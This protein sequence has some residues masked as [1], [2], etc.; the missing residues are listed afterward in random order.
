MVSLLN[1]TYSLEFTLYKASTPNRLFHFRSGRPATKCDT[2]HHS[3]MS[4]AGRPDYDQMDEL[5]A[6]D[7]EEDSDLPPRDETDGRGEGA[8][9]WWEEKVRDALEDWGWEAARGAII[10]SEE[11]DVVAS[12]LDDGRRIIVQCKDWASSTVTPATVWRLIG[13]C[14]TTGCRPVLAITSGLTRRAARICLHWWVSVITPRD[15]FGSKQESLP[16][17]EQSVRR[18]DHDFRR[19]RNPDWRSR[20]RDSRAAEILTRNQADYQTRQWYPRYD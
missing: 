13:L 14:Y 15:V 17:A 1:G 18:L 10:W 2:R 16:D 12:N 11:T 7:T 8:G 3:R 20:L 6:D 4:D 5:L 9:S 19:E